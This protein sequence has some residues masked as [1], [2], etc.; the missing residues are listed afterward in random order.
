MKATLTIH[1]H[2]NFTQTTLRLWDSNNTYTERSVCGRDVV[3]PTFLK[4]KAVDM[5]DALS[6]VTTTQN[7]S[8]PTFPYPAF[9]DIQLTMPTGNLME[10]VVVTSARF[11]T[12]KGAIDFASSFSGSLITNEL[13]IAV[14]NKLMLRIANNE[15]DEL[16]KT[17]NGLTAVSGK[18]LEK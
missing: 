18:K 5:W 12:P 2:R 10:E 9:L 13:R 4:L 16:I 7:E 3:L 14:I 8:F 17:I 1:V 6:N 15:G 11:G